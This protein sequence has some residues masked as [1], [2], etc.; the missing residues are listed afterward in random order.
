MT[1]KS[2]REMVT[3]EELISD[4]EEVY[5]EVLFDADLAV[6]Q[7]NLDVGVGSRGYLYLIHPVL[8]ETQK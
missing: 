5:D 7:I 2:I 3:I 4:K 8:F 1:R 6:K